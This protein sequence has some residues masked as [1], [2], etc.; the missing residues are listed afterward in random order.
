M[1]CGTGL[2]TFCPVRHINEDA[3]LLTAAQ[4]A[5]NSAPISSSIL[6]I[7]GFT[8][9]SSSRCRKKHR[10]LRC[11]GH[12][13]ACQ[14]EGTESTP[15][16]TSAKTDKTHQCKRSSHVLRVDARSVT[17]VHVVG[18]ASTANAPGLQ[19]AC[20]R[21]HK[22]FP[23]QK[24]LSCHH[25]QT[26]T[27]NA[28]ARSCLHTPFSHVNDAHVEFECMGTSQL[29]SSQRRELLV[30]SVVRE[31][32][33]AETSQHHIASVFAK[34]SQITWWCRHDKKANLRLRLQ[35]QFTR[36]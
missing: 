11:H 30:C 17:H 23:S 7:G 8:P 4:R 21:P 16:E 35:N 20:K 36:L 27:R 12:C 34:S 10:P 32:L 33:L 1:T 22:K 9:A 24:K 6:V 18:E 14:H 25:V 31:V 28:A 13:E 26:S 2:S 3:I 29:M 15:F 19:Q 5:A